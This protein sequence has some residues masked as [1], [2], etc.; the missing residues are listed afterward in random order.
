[1]QVEGAGMRFIDEAQLRR[2]HFAAMQGEKAHTGFLALPAPNGSSGLSWWT[3][4][5]VPINADA[6]VIKDAY[7][8]LVAKHHPDRGGDVEMFHRVQEAYR[9]FSQLEKAAA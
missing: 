3:V 8:I 2:G 6:A 7:R 9:Q 1:M 4:L 5:G